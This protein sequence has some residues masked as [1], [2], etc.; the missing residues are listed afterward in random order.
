ML[1]MAGNLTLPKKTLMSE[2]GT[3]SY[4]GGFM[5]MR[6]LA[7]QAGDLTIGNSTSKTTVQTFYGNDTLRGGKGND[8]LRGSNGDETFIYGK[9]DGK[10]VIN[11]F[12]DNDLLKITGTFSTSYSKSKGEVYFKVGSTSKAITLHDFTATSFHVNG[13]TYKI[14]GS[15]LVKK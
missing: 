11:G 4:A 12:D 8:S 3:N 1:E 15:K 14:S 7:R 13:A 9:G 5:F 10:D 2:A 6:Y